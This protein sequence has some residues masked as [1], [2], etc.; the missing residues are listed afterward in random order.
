[1]AG[2]GLRGG[3]LRIKVWQC[4]RW[5]ACSLSRNGRGSRAVPAAYAVG[6]AG[7]RAGLPHRAI[8]PRTGSGCI[9][10]ATTFSHPQRF[11]APSS[12]PRILPAARSS[13]L[14]AA[15]AASDRSAACR[16]FGQSFYYGQPTATGT[17]KR[18]SVMLAPGNAGHLAIPWTTI[19]CLAQHQ[20][21]EHTE[22]RLVVV[23]CFDDD[24]AVASRHKQRTGQGAST[25][26]Q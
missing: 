22:G 13:C 11:S 10:N 18:V 5:L 3:G 1:M 8:G 15:A 16:H 25:A 26:G 2:G 19:G 24:D 17:P 23:T 4:A 14:G 7:R 20:A 9:A 21:G 12:R 6:L